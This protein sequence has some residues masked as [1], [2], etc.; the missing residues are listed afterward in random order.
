MSDRSPGRLPVGDRAA[1]ISD[2]G[3]YRYTLERRLGDGPAVLFLML[4]PSTAD[5]D[6]DDNTIRRCIGFARRWGYGTLLVGN[7]YAY[8]ATQPEELDTVDDPIGPE[9][10]RHLWELVER[11]DLIVAA[12]GS[13]PA[14][15]RFKHR[16]RAVLHGPLFE[17]DVQA[18]RITKDGH[19]GHPLYVPAVAELVPYGREDARV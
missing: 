15:G 9:N 13:K 7:L 4:N 6:V 17:R 2:C 8:R 3:R 18:L 11:A 10:D 12:W 16:E 19:P 1:V 5:A 14:R